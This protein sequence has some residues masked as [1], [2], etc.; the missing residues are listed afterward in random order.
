MNI[1]SSSSI[2]FSKDIAEKTEVKQIETDYEKIKNRYKVLFQNWIVVY[3]SLLL[4]FNTFRY[5]AYTITNASDQIKNL[6]NAKYN[7]LRSI[8]QAHI[9]EGYKL[10]HYFR[11]DLTKQKIVYNLLVGTEKTKILDIEVDM[12]TLLEKATLSTANSYGKISFLDINNKEH[13]NVTDLT[14]RIET[15]Y[16]KLS[17]EAEIKEIMNPSYNDNDL[18]FAG[19]ALYNHLMEIYYNKETNFNRGHVYEMYKY[20]TMHAKNPYNKDKRLKNPK[21]KFITAVWKFV[22]NS[23]KSI[24]GGDTARRNEDGTYTGIQLKNIT[25]ASAGLINASSIRKW[26]SQIINIFSLKNKKQIQNSFKQLLTEKMDNLKGQKIQQEANKE[27]QKNIDELIS[28][29]FDKFKK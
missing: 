15:Q 19:N 2:D 5:N 27:A 6:N 4:Q 16:T 1:K 14:L 3:D 25:K 23:T 17:K 29:H 24:Q 7:N 20:L 21:T 22:K 28:K 12:E 10:I 8:L 11:E 9:V 13:F 26:M 18:V